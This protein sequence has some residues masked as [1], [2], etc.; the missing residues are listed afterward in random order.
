MTIAGKFVK[1]AALTDG[2]AT[3][4][5]KIA[6]AGY[7]QARLEDLVNSIESLQICQLQQQGL[8]WCM[9]ISNATTAPGVV[10]K[11]QPSHHQAGFCA[12]I[13]G[14]PTMCWPVWSANPSCTV[15]S[16]STLPAML[17]RGVESTSLL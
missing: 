6:G 9:R 5:Q 3:W 4:G 16:T 13:E 17:K 11:V 15:T 8:V 14:A 10:Y 12:V 2:S 1:G 7:Q